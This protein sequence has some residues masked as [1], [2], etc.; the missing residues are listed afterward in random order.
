MGEEVKIL[1]MKRKVVE[2]TYIDNLHSVQVAS[3]GL[4]VTVK[5]FS[6]I[7]SNVEF[8]LEGLGMFN[9][10]ADALTEMRKRGF[11]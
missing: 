7:Y 6:Q 2:H 5:I 11:K 4:K 1:T 8:E 3:D 10:L 9:T